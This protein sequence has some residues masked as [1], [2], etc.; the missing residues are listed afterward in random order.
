M[1]TPLTPD[2]LDLFEQHDYLSHRIARRHWR[3]G[4]FASMNLL[5]L[6]QEARIGLLACCRQYDPDAGVF[7]HYASRSMSRRVRLAIQRGRWGPNDFRAKPP[8]T[9]MLVGIPASEDGLEQVRD[10]STAGARPAFTPCR[11]PE[12]QDRI[13]AKD[14]LEQVVEMGNRINPGFGAI[15][16]EL[17]KGKTQQQAIESSGVRISRVGLGRWISKVRA[18]MLDRQA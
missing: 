10:I 6:T 12:L 16:D 3:R 13:D 11:L 18:K 4:L 2:Q 15:V 14:T 17:L 7:E 1:V 5:D 8:E 9:E